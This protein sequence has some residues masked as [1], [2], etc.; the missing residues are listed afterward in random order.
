MDESMKMP[1]G[2]WTWVR[3]R[4][5]ALLGGDLDAPMGSSAFEG[6]RFQQLMYWLVG[7]T[8]IRPVK[9]LS[10]GVQAWLSVW[11]EVQTCMRLS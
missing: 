10:G 3:P 6:G 1:I 7:R 9:K 2:V 4:D 11:S 5:H 8:G